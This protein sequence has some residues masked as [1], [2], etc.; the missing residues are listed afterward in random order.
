MFPT[1]CT[2]R[3]FFLYF[4]F[5][6]LKAPI[7]INTIPTT[8]ATTETI[9]IM[10]PC[11]KTSLQSKKLILKAKGLPYISALLTALTK[12]AKIP[13]VTQT[14]PLFNTQFVLR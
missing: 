8:K 11:K 9:S 1:V 10:F 7:E 5:I 13:P 12:N 2:I 3:Q 6:C 14:I 4:L